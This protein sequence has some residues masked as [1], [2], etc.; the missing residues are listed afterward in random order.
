MTHKTVFPDN[1]IPKFE[2]WN[3]YIKTMTMAMETKKIPFSID[4]INTEINLIQFS[5][6]HHVDFIPSK[7]D[8]IT[9]GFKNGHWFIGVNRSKIFEN[10]NDNKSVNLLIQMIDLDISSFS[11]EIINFE[12]PNLN[13]E[14][15]KYLTRLLKKYLIDQLDKNVK[16]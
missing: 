2:I 9:T 8:V 3:S 10:I 13:M 15:K 4:K 5:H 12:L 16:F 1:Y 6:E 14:M 11:W 7:N